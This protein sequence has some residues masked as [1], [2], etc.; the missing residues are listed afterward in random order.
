MAAEFN[1]KQQ[2]VE[3]NAPAFFNP[4]MSAALAKKLDDICASLKVLT[5]KTTALNENKTMEVNE[6]LE[7]MMTYARQ[8]K[9]LLALLQAL[10]L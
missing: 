4:E 10:L 2:E 8:K 6:R 1:E 7:L 9:N 3:T 5:E